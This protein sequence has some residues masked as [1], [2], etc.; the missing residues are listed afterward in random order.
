MAVPAATSSDILEQAAMQ[1]LVLELT[2]ARGDGPGARHLVR[3][4]PPPDPAQPP[5]EPGMWAQVMGERP[6]ELD[7][8]IR[9]QT[10]VESVF[11][12]AD[13]RYAFATSVLRRVPGL[14]LTERVAVHAVELQVPDLVQPTPRRH[15]PR[16]LV[17]GNGIVGELSAPERDGGDGGLRMVSRQLWDVSS[18]GAS[19]ICMLGQSLPPVPPPGGG[20]EPPP[21][22]VDMRLFG[23]T[24]RMLARACYVRW[25][26]LKTA[27]VGVQF[28]QPDV[29]YV[30]CV[31]EQIRRAEAAGRRGISAVAA[32]RPEGRVA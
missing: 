8:L 12:L 23:R 14:W 5:R 20:D 26:S 29:E 22:T 3:L 11:Y 6:R 31:A 2:A 17:C 25:L 18:V 15:D 24:Y 28:L 19:F 9:E 32:Q 21:L 30:A 7:V 13:G 10:P 1:R 16:M 27:R 4:L